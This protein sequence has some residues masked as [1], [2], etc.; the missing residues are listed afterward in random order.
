MNMFQQGEWAARDERIDVVNPFN[1]EAVDTVPSATPADVSSA[2]D[3]LA[4]GAKLMAAM[5]A[6][7]R[8]AILRKAAL[9]LRER[10]DEVGTLIST[11]E[12]KILGE[13]K[14]EVDHSRS[15]IEKIKSVKEILI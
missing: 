14:L 1:S 12:G 5:P 9:L 7:E 4:A 10:E 11:E 8:C 15:N 3:G 13:G 6:M 2:V